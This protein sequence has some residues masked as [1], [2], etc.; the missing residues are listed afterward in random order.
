MKFLSLQKIRVM[1]NLE[2]LKS[3]LIRAVN[4][5]SDRNQLLK[6]WEILNSKNPSF[7]AESPSIY[8]SEKPMT[9]EEVEEYFREEVVVLPPHLLKM[10]E[11]GMDDVENGRVYTEE[12]MD[13]MDEEWLN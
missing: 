1:E 13:K 8:E 4:E 2:N 3:K 11:R 12:E 7:V 5:S 9:E 6:I 10:V